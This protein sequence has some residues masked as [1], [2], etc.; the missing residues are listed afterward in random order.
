MER[1]NRLVDDAKRGVSL[2]PTAEPLRSWTTYPLSN[3]PKPKVTTGR[4]RWAS[5]RPWTTSITPSK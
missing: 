2:L 1:G 3:F 4:Y 5:S